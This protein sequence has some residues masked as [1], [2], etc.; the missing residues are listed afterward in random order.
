MRNIIVNQVTATRTSTG[1]SVL[2]MC[3][4]KYSNIINN[5]MHLKRRATIRSISVKAAKKSM[6]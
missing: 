1:I 3:N 6:T 5:I 4:D 2:I